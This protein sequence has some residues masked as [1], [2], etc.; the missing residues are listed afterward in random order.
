[1][2][3]ENCYGSLDL[4]KSIFGRSWI[5]RSAEKVRDDLEKIV[6][7]AELVSDD[8]GKVFGS[9][10]NRTIADLIEKNGHKIDRHS[11]LLEEPIKALGIYTIKIK[12][13]KDVEA[14]VKLFV[15]KKAS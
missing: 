10:T 12:V 3:C 4:Q 9:V 7:T 6:L 5:C 13:E 1:M 8:D 11:I 14:N 2:A 15:E